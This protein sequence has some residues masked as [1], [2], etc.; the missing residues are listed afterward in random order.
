[1]IDAHI[2]V[3]PPQLPGAGSLSPLL[4]APPEDTEGA[5]SLVKREMES[6]AAL[7]VPL[8]VTVGVGKNWVDAKE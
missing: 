6:A 5:R 7:R 3:V 1:M 4:E 2:H 8:V